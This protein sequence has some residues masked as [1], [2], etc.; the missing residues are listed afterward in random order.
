MRFFC[1]ILVKALKNNGFFP[2]NFQTVSVKEEK[3]EMRSFVL[4]KGGY[5]DDNDVGTFVGGDA[6]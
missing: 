6:S 4:K 3:L 2:F 5:Q 1:P